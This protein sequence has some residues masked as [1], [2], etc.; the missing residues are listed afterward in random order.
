MC[1]K[2]FA[3]LIFLLVPF[4]AQAQKEDF[5]T[6][7]NFELEGE[8][9]NLVDFT[10]S[11]ELRLWDNSTR[12]ES[13]LARTSLSVPVTKFLR[14]GVR[15]R[16]QTDY[17]RK[18]YTKY[19]HRYGLWAEFDY[20]IARLRMAYRA[21]YQNEYTNFSRSEDGRHPEI[22]HRHKVSFKYRGKGWDITPLLAAEMFFLIRPKEINYQQKLRLTAGFKYRITKD[23]K[24]NLSYKYQ[25]EYYE[26]N[27]LTSHIISTGIE[28]EL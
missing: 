14:L 13:V 25:Q 15:Y 26:N 19:I 10:V 6:W 12:L 9:F 21:I 23:L 2:I 20:K 7:Y 17:V 3:F 11:P 27:P 28:Y 24:L 8:L 16:Y 22:V 1:R 5:R 18:D 4:L